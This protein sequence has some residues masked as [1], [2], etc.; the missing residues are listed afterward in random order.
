MPTEKKYPEHEVPVHKR[1][2]NVIPSRDTENDWRIEHATE[3]GILEAAPPIPS[4]VDLREPWWK[5]G[6]QGAT[7]SCV[8]W[9]TADSLL[10]WHFVKAGRLDRNRL[11]SQRFIWMAAKETDEFALRPT[12]FIEA[13]GTSLKAALT[14]A[15]KYGVVPD[16]LLPFASG[17]LFGGEEKT[18][19]V[20]ASRLRIANYI[21]LGSDLAQWRKWIAT[22]GPIL[23]RLDVDATWDHAKE[24]DGH[25]AEYQPATVRG[26]H[27]VALVGYTSDYFIVR[28]SWGTTLWGDKGFGYASPEY[29]QAAFTEAYGVTL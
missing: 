21:N 24:T 18:F 29:A 12:T 27:A 11:L 3:A 10:R 14:I 4:S 13:D 17:A 28:N 16:D 7:G 19:Y 9:A 15:Q 5:I 2:L 1:I 6:D 8:G 26:G 20:I 25:L 23:T 22:N